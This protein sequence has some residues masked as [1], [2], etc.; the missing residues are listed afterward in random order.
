MALEMRRDL[1]AEMLIGYGASLSEPDQDG[2]TC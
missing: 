2:V 1:V